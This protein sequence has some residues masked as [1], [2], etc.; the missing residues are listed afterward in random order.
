M[1]DRKTNRI[2]REVTVRSFVT[3]FDPA[4]FMSLAWFKEWKTCVAWMYADEAIKE[5]DPW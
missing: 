2:M 5:D 3:A 1:W 4:Q